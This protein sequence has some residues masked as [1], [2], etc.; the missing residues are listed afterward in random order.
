MNNSNYPALV[1]VYLG[2]LP[3]YIK[4][5]LILNARYN[6]I[7]LLCDTTFAHSI[8]N[9]TVI[10][11]KIFYTKNGF[12]RLAD[13][14]TSNFRDGFWLKTIERF[15]VLAA[16]MK[17]Y[18]IEKLFHGEIDNLIFGLEDLPYCLDKIGSGL[19][20]PLLNKKI[21]SASIMYINSAL[22][23]DSLCSYFGKQEIFKDDMRMLAEYSEFSK[24]VFLLPSENNLT[25][26]LSMQIGNENLIFDVAS[27]GQYLF[28]IDLRNSGR[29]IFNKFENTHCTADF[30][31]IKFMVDVLSNEFN[32]QING[33]RFRLMNIHIHSK[34]FK[35]IY[36]DKEF[37]FRLVNKIN[38]GVSTLISIN[39]RNYSVRSVL[40]YIRYI[41][42]G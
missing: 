38:R 37:T 1:F 20:Y 31:K 17:Y 12:D 22:E 3:D 36:C 15:F 39:V 35:K 21:A 5:S 11:T 2:K 19:F 40:G 32:L 33:K 24:N 42:T 13:E 28:G 18:N 6:N 16:Y 30:S 4:Y 27:F 14:A 41:F 25:G 9:V 23:L 29:P 34:I 26:E 7:I 8:K 10:S